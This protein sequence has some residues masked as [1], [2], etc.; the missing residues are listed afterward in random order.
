MGG[1]TGGNETDQSHHRQRAWHYIDV[2]QSK[3]NIWGDARTPTYSPA[4][5]RYELGERVT[6]T[7]TPQSSSPF[8]SPTL[9]YGLNLGDCFP[10][11]R[12]KHTP[13]SLCK[14]THTHTHTL[15]TH[16]VINPCLPSMSRWNGVGKQIDV[17]VANHQ[18]AE[19][20]LWNNCWTHTHTWMIYF[21]SI[22]IRQSAIT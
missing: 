1:H 11:E 16:N 19:Q 5:D 21:F 22:Y 2:K 15:C 6:H 8:P 4:N 10:Q 20:W 14:D 18:S 13:A 12:E 9:I 7:H 3:Y 17:L